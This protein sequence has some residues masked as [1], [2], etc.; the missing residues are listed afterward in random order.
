MKGFLKTPAAVFVLV[1]VVAV[2]AWFF[3]HSP[4][5]PMKTGAE[6]TGVTPR[7]EIE[8]TTVN[9]FGSGK[10]YFAHPKDGTAHPGVVMI[11]EWWGLTDSVKQ[12]ADQL[13]GQGYSVLAVDLFG[14]TVAKDAAEAQWLVSNLDYDVAL[15]NLK[16]AVAFARAQGASKVASLGWCFGGGQSLALA[17]SGEHLDATV[18]Y[19]GTPLLTDAE[20]LKHIAWPVLGI[21]GDRD[22]ALPVD[23]VHSFENA[24]GKVGIQSEVYI[25]PGVGHAFA[26]PT[27]QNFSPKETKDAWGKTLSFLQTY[28]QEK[29]SP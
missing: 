20:K 2:C 26:N 21:F 1:A 28:L 15:A 5:S 6:L 16:A 7:N 12:M 29:N 22:A 11:H 17:V 10:G 25:Y 13:A 14:G 3:I 18:L 27:G 4:T 24:L 8:T 23:T 9:Y 19:Y